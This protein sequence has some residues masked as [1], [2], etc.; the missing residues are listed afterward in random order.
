M[1]SASLRSFAAAVA[2]AALLVPFA[3]R[4]TL[5]IQHWQTASGARVLFVETHELPMIDLAVDFPAGTSRDTPDKSGLAS[6]ALGLMRSGAGGM[7]ENEISE[8]LAN[9]GADL[10]GRFDM[11]RGGYGLRTLSSARERDEALAVLTAILQKPEYPQ[12]VFAR[13][14]Q[15]VL[16]ALR[17]AQTRPEVLAEREFKHLLYGNHPYSMR[18]AGEA[19]T[20]ATLTRAD[21]VDFYRDHFL[22]DDA[23]VSIIGDLTRDQ[24]V[25][26]AEQLTAGLA[27]GS[28]PPPALPPV[29]PLQAAQL[30]RIAHPATQAHILIGQP[31]IKRLDPDYFPLFLG[32][33]VLGGGGFASR[34]NDE[35]R[36]KRG[37]AY[38][39]YSFFNPMA[40]EGPFQIAVQTKKEQTEEALKVAQDTLAKFIEDGPTA[41][42]LDAAKQNIIGGF[43]LRIDSNKKIQEYLSIIG[44]YDLPLTYLDD[45]PLRIEQLTLEQVKDAWR[46]RIHPDRMATVVVAGGVAPT[47]DSR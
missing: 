37:Y 10:S 23:V 15:R 40:Q 29:A 6:L 25:A 41:Q 5:P 17:E 18:G 39:T 9:I 28:A 27:R 45:F 46:R 38:S 8:R 36:Q 2:V 1:T 12:D 19:D 43:P 34:L 20:V 11:D 7:N 22:A 4:A 33:Y 42:E 44:F 32:N 26:I 14:Q 35:I 13:E 24:A 3:A 21:L 30:S 31:G 47:A 16:A